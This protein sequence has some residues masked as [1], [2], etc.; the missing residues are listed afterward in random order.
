MTRIL[1]KNILV[2]SGT[3]HKSYKSITQKMDLSNTVFFK[4]DLV[5]HINI[6]LEIGGDLYLDASEI[7]RAFPHKNHTKKAYENL[8]TWILQASTW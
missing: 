3:K 4:S 1:E 7:R 5:V 8:T 6:Y 2:P